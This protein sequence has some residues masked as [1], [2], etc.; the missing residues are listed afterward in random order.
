[1]P[2]RGTPR[3]FAT[4][5]VPVGIVADTKYEEAEEKKVTQ[6]YPK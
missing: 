5:G 3:L 2:G 1:M 6:K 4:T